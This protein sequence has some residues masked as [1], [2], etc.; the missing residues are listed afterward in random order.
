MFFIG[1]LYSSIALLVV[2]LLFSKDSV[3]SKYGGILTVL[4]TVLF[5]FP[6]MYFIIKFE[7]GKDVLISRRGRLL[8]EHSKAIK[9]LMWL[10]LGLVVG[11]SFWYILLPGLGESSFNAQVEVYCA[12]NSPGNFEKCISDSNFFTGGVTR[13]ERFMGI[14]ANNVNVLIVTLIFSL[15]FGAGAIFILVWNAS[16]IAA[17][18]GIFARNNLSQ[19][20]VGFFR[21]MIHGI[22]EIAAY[23]VGALAGG[24]ISVAIIRRDLM[25]ERKWKIIE[26]ALLLVLVA[27]L[28]L[29]FAGI[30]EVWVTPLIF[31]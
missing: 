24:I 16:V 6:F 12:I 5:C 13:P 26:D 8:R 30:I 2:A 15:L 25:G 18:I 7:E 27:V 19:L 17:A 22:P 31:G 3:L 10:F 11:F 9:A 1:L 28:I 23:F 20:P 29:V 4:L 21:Y 14:F